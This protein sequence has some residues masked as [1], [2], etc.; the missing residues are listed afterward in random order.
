M[1]RS[2]LVAAAALLVST[3]AA[4]AQTW[5]DGHFRKDG[6]YV[7]G[8]FAQQDPYSQRKVRP[9]DYFVQKRPPKV[10]GPQMPEG[11]ESN[12]PTTRPS[13]KKPRTRTDPFKVPR[14]GSY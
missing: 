4:Q 10:Q 6:T 11:F 13:W 8:H 9:E 12:M 7:P 2:V 1:V 5:V 14:D 3:G